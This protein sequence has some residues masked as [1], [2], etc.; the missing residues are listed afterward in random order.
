MKSG[1]K[2]PPDAYGVEVKAEL[3]YIGRLDDISHEGPLWEVTIDWKVR[4]LRRDK[5][6]RPKMADV[7]GYRLTVDDNDGEEED[8]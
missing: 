8:A 3:G 6:E 1:R 5:V 7:E 2:R 4:R